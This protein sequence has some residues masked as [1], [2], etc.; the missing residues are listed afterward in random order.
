M[1]KMGSLASYGV[2]DTRWGFSGLIGLKDTIYTL[3]IPNEYEEACAVFQHLSSY[4]V[5]FMIRWQ[6]VRKPEE[7]KS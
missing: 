6:Q 5:A 2:T 1:T 7:Y 4:S 3:K